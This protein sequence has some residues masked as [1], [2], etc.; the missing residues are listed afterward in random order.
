MKV[1]HLPL[2]FIFFVVQHVAAQNTEF[3]SFSKE[4][5]KEYKALVLPALQIGYIQNLEAIKT[6]SEVLHQEK[7]FK[8]FRK[9]IK[10][11]NP[12][13]L[14]NHEKLDY[15]IIQYEIALNLKRISLEKKWHRPDSIPSTGLFTLPN[16]KKW[17]AYFL[18][19]WVDKDV[20]PDQL[21]KFGLKEIER[22]KA[23]MKAIQT[24]SGMDSLAF[25]KHINSPSFFYNDVQEI[26][27]AFEQLKETV[28]KNI[29]HTYPYLTEI[30]EVKIDQGTNQALAQ[31]PGFYSGGTFY[32]NVFGKPY[33][34][35]QIGWL[36]LHEA[37]PG[38]HYQ[39]MSVNALKRSSIQ[40]LFS[41]YGYME[42]WAAYIEEFGKELGA[43]PTLYDELGKWEWDII[44]S[45][46]VA[47]DVAINYYGWSDEKALEFWQQHIQGQD[48][49]ARREIARMKRWPAQVITY[50]YGANK[51]LTWRAE[52]QKR[53]DFSLMEFHK[54]VLQNGSLPYSILEKLIIK[55][56]N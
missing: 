41:Y 20:T 22:V 9:R 18:Q 51:L 1:K 39:I 7:V 5:E 23:N 32:Y 8:G 52:W 43:Y 17:Y 24:K 40:K 37:M 25:Q 55:A 56:A 36:Y 48:D 33:N 47:L 15:D 10:N 45:V 21:F 11:I 16:G 49:I 26:Q 30:P 31:T 2:A 19:K 3:T 28:S 54:T 53:A 4:F 34:K 38:H 35:R 6:K 46:R 13:T 14:S 12:S 50:K 27:Q 42:G 44:R 29:A